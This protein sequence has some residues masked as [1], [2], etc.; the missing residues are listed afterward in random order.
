MKKIEISE[1][2]IMGVSYYIIENMKHKEILIERVMIT[3]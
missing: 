3:L 1:S 2:E